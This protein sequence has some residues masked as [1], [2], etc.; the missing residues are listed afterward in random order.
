MINELE[1]DE[2]YGKPV[3]LSCD[4]EKPTLF[5]LMMLKFGIKGF[6]TLFER[7]K[8]SRNEALL[9]RLSV[10][11]KEKEKF[12]AYPF[13]AKAIQELDEILPKYLAPLTQTSL[14]FLQSFRRT[15]TKLRLDLLKTDQVEL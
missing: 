14:G 2:C 5:R 3:I 11:L 13:L 1:F 6:M 9:E 4:E 15:R 8:S 10:L 12:L 7:L